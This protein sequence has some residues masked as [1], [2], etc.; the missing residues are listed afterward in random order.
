MLYTHTCTCTHTHAS[1]VDDKQMLE[2]R[3]KL[4][5]FRTDVQAQMASTLG[6]AWDSDSKDNA[7]RVL[8][9][10]VRVLC[11]CVVS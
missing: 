2:I 5:Q 10:V 4:E 9:G 6:I 1:G 8:C 7:V 3:S 11:S